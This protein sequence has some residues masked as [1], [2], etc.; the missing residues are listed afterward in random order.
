[1]LTV[2]VYLRRGGQGG[3]NPARIAAEMTRWMSRSPQIITPGSGEGQTPPPAPAPGRGVAV[4][5]TGER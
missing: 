3:R 5:R 2:V 1:M 4:R